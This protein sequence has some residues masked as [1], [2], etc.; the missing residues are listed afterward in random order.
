MKSIIKKLI[1]LST[2][3]V[4]AIPLMMINV[5]AEDEELDIIAAAT[6][7][8]STMEGF[9][10]VKENVYTKT[11][12]INDGTL[13][14]VYP[15]IYDL[16]NKKL[17][18]STSATYG[19]FPSTQTSSA[20][21][22]TANT[23]V[24]GRTYI[25]TVM[26]YSDSI[27][28]E[29]NGFSFS[30][31]LFKY[32]VQRTLTTEPSFYATGVLNVDFTTDCHVYQ[33]KFKDSNGTELTE[34][35]AND[36]KNGVITAKYIFIVFELKDPNNPPPVPKPTDYNNYI[37]MT[38]EDDNTN[39]NATGDI[40]TANQTDEEKE[41]GYIL[42]YSNSWVKDETQVGKISFAVTDNKLYHSYFI[43]ISE[44]K[45]IYEKV[46]KLMENHDEYIQNQEDW[47]NHIGIWDEVIYNANYRILTDTEKIYLK[48][49]C[50]QMQAVPFELVGTV[51]HESWKF[52]S[53]K[54]PYCETKVI[55]L[56]MCDY[57][58]VVRDDVYKIELVDQI[59]KQ[60][61]DTTYIY[62]NET[63]NQN[64][65][66][67]GSKI[68]DYENEEDAYDDIINNEPKDYDE[69]NNEG[70][71]DYNSNYEPFSGDIDYNGNNAVVDLDETLADINKYVSQTEK[72]FQAC[73]GLLP[74]EMWVVIGTGFAVLI[75]IGIFK[76]ALG[77]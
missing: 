8:L 77:K 42:K 70:D 51:S 65:T 61:L 72:F 58:S 34:Q 18:M 30:N 25:N 10:C 53:T 31:G 57:F 49:Y 69:Y 38:T 39:G 4:I 33:W 56:D 45:V 9:K 67:Y 46:G 37:T 6:E 71:G 76:F 75:A 63:K 35:N 59:T 60:V 7:T 47:L 44:N 40:L 19:Y 16:T 36:M 20:L 48:K 23:H 14:V 29:W 52:S 28:L 64:T 68:Y 24:S 11:D 66:P 50:Q 32:S 12:T 55:S 15:A 62:A 26:T 73:Y 5:S 2:A 1:A 54:Q 13:E 43:R 17:Y 41:Q 22:T 27:R 3:L 74:A 21:H